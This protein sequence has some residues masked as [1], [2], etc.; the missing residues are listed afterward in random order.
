VLRVSAVAEGGCVL[1]EAWRV[2]PPTNAAAT[3]VY[4][5]R[6]R[7]PGPSLAIS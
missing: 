4:D 7:C 3:P 1:K 2:Y 5:L 6:V